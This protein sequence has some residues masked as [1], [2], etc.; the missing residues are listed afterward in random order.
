[1]VEDFILKKGESHR[2]ILDVGCGDGNLLIKIA[3]RNKF[4]ELWCTDPYVEYARNNMMR[5]GYSS[6]IKCIDAKAEDIPL[7]NHSFDFVYSVRSL[8][9]FSNPVKA[10][11]EIK[12]LL[13]PNGEIII[14]DWKK[15]A[16]TG[17][18]ERY[19]GKEELIE[20]MKRA[21]YDEHKISIEESGKFNI[22][23]YSRRKQS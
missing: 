23:S 17:V 8:H 21:G 19:Y 3:K 14:I 4:V 20:F 18:R 6:R 1:M 9:E 7:S 16:D 5:K 12:R 22:L 11:K 10:L 2:K 15:G 13:T